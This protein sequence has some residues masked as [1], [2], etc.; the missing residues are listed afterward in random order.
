MP[1]YL[2]LDDAIRK[3]LEELVKEK[4]TNLT[5]LCLMSNITPSTVFDFMYGKSKYPIIITLKKLC[6]GAGITLKEFFDR[7]YFNGDE[8]V[9][10]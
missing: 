5:A 7:E 4:D 6:I 9:Y 10:K 1:K 8:D 3:R 2:N